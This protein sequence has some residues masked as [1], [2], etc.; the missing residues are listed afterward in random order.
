MTEEPFLESSEAFLLAEVTSKPSLFAKT[1]TPP[2]P[3]TLTIGRNDSVNLL[4]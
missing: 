2:Q 3:R 1:A 4:R